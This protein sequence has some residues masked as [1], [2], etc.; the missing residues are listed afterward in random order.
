MNGCL[1]WPADRL[2]C[3]QPD[4]GNYD[5]EPADGDRPSVDFE[6]LRTSL[7]VVRTRWNRAAATSMIYGSYVS[8][9]RVSPE[10]QQPE[11]FAEAR[12]TAMTGDVLGSASI[13]LPRLVLGRPVRERSD[14][15]LRVIRFGGF[16]LDLHAGEL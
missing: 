11:Q 5:D 6:H 9:S 4:D 14:L 12:H 1:I 13:P 16:E 8:R 15:G 3:L 2:P 7:W 10:P